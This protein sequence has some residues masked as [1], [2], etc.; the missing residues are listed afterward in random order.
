MN[1]DLVYQIERINRNTLQEIEEEEVGWLRNNNY[2]VLLVY[3][4]KI[5]QIRCCILRIFYR[6]FKIR[7]QAKLTLK[8]YG[9]Y[10]VICL[11]YAKSQR[12]EFDDQPGGEYGPVFM[13]EVVLAALWENNL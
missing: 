11:G 5:M 3:D 9:N 13:E 2:L 4:S 10:M 12:R 8:K 1:D 7:T 6:H